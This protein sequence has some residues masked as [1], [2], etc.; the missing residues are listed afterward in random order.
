MGW[1]DDLLGDFFQAPYRRAY[2]SGEP[3]PPPPPQQPVDNKPFQVGDVLGFNALGPAVMREINPFYTEKAAPQ[4]AAPQ[5]P[6]TPLPPRGPEFAEVGPGYAPPKMEPPTRE[7]TLL[8][9]GFSNYGPGI[10]AKFDRS[11][12][13]GSGFGK[14]W[15]PASSG[16]AASPNA[17][18][19]ADIEHR[20][21]MRGYNRQIEEAQAKQSLGIAQL[22]PQ[23]VTNLKNPDAQRLAAAQS[24]V[25]TEQQ[26]I[27]RGIEER[28]KLAAAKGITFDPNMII[29]G[30]RQK[31]QQDLQQAMIGLAGRPNPNAF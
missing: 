3:E 26:Y 2:N 5:A 22:P 21:T 30:L 19:N 18:T 29:P 17:F 13:Q 4:P 9:Q 1:Y 7:Q 24:I 12:T 16:G 15:T 11:K 28:Q 8:N 31:Y 20:E 23:Q 14:T 27:Q 10:F 25:G 6:P